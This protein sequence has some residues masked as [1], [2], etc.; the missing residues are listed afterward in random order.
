[1]PANFSAN[2]MQATGPALDALGEMVRKGCVNLRSLEQ[3]TWYFRA[4]E[5]IHRQATLEYRIDSRRQASAAAVAPEEPT[6][7]SE[8]GEEGS[9]NDSVSARNALQIRKA[10]LEADGAMI[11]T[12]RRSLET[13]REKLRRKEGE[14]KSNQEVKDYS[15]NTSFSTKAGRDDGECEDRAATIIH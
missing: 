13:E 11:A 10:T 2:E 14:R 9:E 6:A 12:L 7:P 5:R 1:M 3:A 8:E 15:D 4:A